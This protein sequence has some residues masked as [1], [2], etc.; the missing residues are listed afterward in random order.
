MT[1]SFL[2]IIA[3]E[4][5]EKTRTKGGLCGGA[6]GGWSRNRWW[7]TSIVEIQP[8]SITWSTFFGCSLISSIPSSLGFPS[9]HFTTSAYEL[10]LRGFMLKLLYIANF[11]KAFS[12]LDLKIL[13]LATFQATNSRCAHHRFPPSQLTVCLRWSNVA[14]I[15]KDLYPYHRLQANLNLHD[16]YQHLDWFLSKA[17]Y[18]WSPSVINFMV[19]DIYI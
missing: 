10:V 16:A 11:R 2:W 3:E 12:L 15:L 14:W 4:K 13:D 1:K 18:L 8:R 6:C 7:R 17:I 5:G 9:T 19:M